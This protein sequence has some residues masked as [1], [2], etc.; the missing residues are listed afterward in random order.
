MIFKNIKEAHKYYKYPS[1]HRFGTIGDNKGVLRSYSNGKGCDY[2]RKS[3]KEIYYKI[4]NERVR[5]L[6][7]LNLKTKQKVRFF[8]KVYD[9]VEDL[10]LYKVIKFTKDS[11]IKLIK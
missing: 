5:S 10:G 9:G 2:Y 4:K 3:G 1:S 8:R 11:F 6:Y 7:S